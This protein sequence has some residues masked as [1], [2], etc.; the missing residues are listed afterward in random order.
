[1]GQPRPEAAETATDASVGWAPTSTMAVEVSG[2]AQQRGG[3]G[4]AATGRR[5]AWIGVAL[6]LWTVTGTF[7]VVRAL[8]DGLA[9]DVGL[10]PYHAVAYGAL[11][12]LTV[13][14]IVRLGLARRSG[15]GWRDAFPAGFGAI[16]A[17]TAVLLVY[18]VADAAWREGVGITD[19]SIEGGFAPSRV[20]LAIGLALVAMAALRAALRRGDPR[21]GWPAAFSGAALVAALASPGGFHPAVNPWFERPLD[22]EPGSEIWVMD[23]DGGRQTR[24]IEA[25]DGTA[26]GNPVWSPGGTRIA[27]TVSPAAPSN[28]RRDVDI[29]VANADGRGAYLLAGGPGWQWFPRWSPDGKWVAYTEEAT[30]GPWLDTGPIGP[31]L[32][33][34]AEGPGFGA[35]GA[36]ARPEADLWRI[37]ADGSGTKARITDTPG[38]DR[39]GSWSPDGRRLAF[40]STRDGNTEIYSVGA[41]GADPVRLTDAPGE[42]WAAAWSPDGRRIAF[43]S[44]RSGTAQVWVMGE[45]GSDPTE[46]TTDPAGNLWPAWSPDGSQLAIASWRTGESQVWAISADGTSPRSLG[47]SRGTSDSVWDGSW[48]PDGRIA[49]MRTQPLEATAAPIAREDLGVAAMLISACLVA[50]VVGLLGRVRPPFG[51]IAVV[52]GL[53]TALLA[54]EGDNWRFVPAALLAGLVADLVARLAPDHRRISASAAV[55]AAGLV[56]GLGATAIVTRGLD[57]SPTLWLGVALAAAVAGWVIGAIV[58]APAESGRLAAPRVADEASGP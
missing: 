32:G 18:V 57:W 15:Q 52:L 37:A 22:P 29:W 16:G 3:H 53:S 8:N 20:L 51:A 23:G 31:A 13:I 26:L 43:T 1:M 11:L 7:L 39:S 28:A 6:G 47:R 54:I 48:G 35:T 56:V 38:D 33:P 30:G 24:L 27:Y 36:A 14:S 25:F 10:S 41:D 55:A 44:D 4:D 58:G 45:D 19:P 2:V 21:L 46:L 50:G 5:W 9:S 12:S 49:F 17:G 42:D 40:D 34:G